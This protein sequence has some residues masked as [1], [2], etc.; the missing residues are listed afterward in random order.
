[1]KILFYSSY[2]YPYISGLTVYP[3]RVLEELQE[4]HKITVLTFPHADS[5]PEKE[6][7][8]GIIIKRLK[9]NFKI[10]KGFISVQSILYFV[11]EALKH[12]IIVIN[13]PNF[14]ALPLA[15]VGRLLGK[16]IIVI[17]CCEVFLG[18]DIISR[19]I[20]FFLN[21]SVFF[22]LLVSDAIVAFPDYIESL[23]VYRLFKGKVIT[24]PPIITEKPVDRTTLKRFKNSKGREVWI[25]F[26]GRLAREK[27]I[28]YLI[29]A[30][31]IIGREGEN[32]RLVFV[33]PGKNE[34]VGENSYADKIEEKLKQKNIPYNFLGILSDQDLG[35]FYKSID[36]LVLPS[37]NRTEAFGMVQAESMLLGT[38]VIS[39]DLP[40]VRLTVKLTG[41]GVSI[42]V[43]N[44]KIFAGAIKRIIKER[45]RFTNRKFIE[46]AQEV[47]SKEKVVNTY[48]DL[49]ARFNN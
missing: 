33:G 28:E 14:E 22:Q 2:F 30:A 36:V 47:F 29:N 49:L 24:C 38:P 23:Y 11:R 34:V 8:N 12:D 32:I 35:A 31:E 43:K 37:V 27:G 21:S 48:E 45:N 17:F 6:T 4:K 10:S 25:G 13:V 1:M 46:R 3:L 41:M 18:K 16:K 40:G 9:Y 5:L 19:I 42:N 7:Y 20:V 39:S 15:I 44:A 26:V